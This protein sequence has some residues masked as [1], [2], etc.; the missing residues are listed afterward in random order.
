MK[1]TKCKMKQDGCEG[2]YIKW[3][4]TQKTCKNPLC[5]ILLMDIEK[6]KKARKADKVTR[7]R[8]KSRREW[9]V[10]AQKSF[11]AYIRQRDKGKLCICCDRP[12]ELNAVGGGYDC[13]H[14]RSVGSAPHLRFNPLNAHAQ[15]KQCNQW[16]SG[17][18]VDY[19]IGLIKRIGL[20]AVETLEADQEPKKYTIEELIEIRRIY[21]QKAKLLKG[22]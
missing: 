14:Y 18:A 6:E 2:S 13:G 22:E 7:E 4:L 12:L 21:T 15:R 3:S 11:N 17:R 16:G 9:L 1:P 5:A 10:D 20:E 8:L 19:R